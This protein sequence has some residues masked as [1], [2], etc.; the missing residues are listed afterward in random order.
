MNIIEALKKKISVYRFIG[1][2]II[3]GAFEK[4]G[5]EIKYSGRRVCAAKV[6]EISSTGELIYS[7]IA[8]FK[9]SGSF[10]INDI[11]DTTFFV[12]WFDEYGKLCDFQVVEK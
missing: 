3:S 10:D 8:T 12:P 11:D 2:E 9:A 6:R 1:S 5:K 7:A 4:D